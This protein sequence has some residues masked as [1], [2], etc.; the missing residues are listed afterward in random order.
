MAEFSG[1]VATKLEV[2]A[3]AMVFG[4][5][6]AGGAGERRYRG[7]RAFLVI[8]RVMGAPLSVR[9]EPQK[10]IDFSNTCLLGGGR[11]GRVKRKGLKVA[12][13][14]VAGEDDDAQ[15]EKWAVMEFG[16]LGLPMMALDLGLSWSTRPKFVMKM[17]ALGLP[18][19]R[20]LGWSRSP[21]PSML[22]EGLMLPMPSTL[23][24]QVHVELAYLATSFLNKF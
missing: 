3:P 13:K 21:G 6:D 12:A 19:V 14:K 24:A 2:V 17:G 22:V 11:P 18:M 20:I 5:G 23:M 1:A 8:P 7:R 16:A 9:V 10:L 15:V 4:R